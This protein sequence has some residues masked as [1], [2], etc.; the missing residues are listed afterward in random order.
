MNHTE[1]CWIQGRMLAE[2]NIPG[3]DRKG[4]QNAMGIGVY[5]RQLLRD[6]AELLVQIE[7]VDMHMQEGW[8]TLW[9]K[10]VEDNEGTEDMDMDMVRKL[11]EDI[12]QSWEEG[13]ADLK[14]VE[15]ENTH[16]FHMDMEIENCTY[17]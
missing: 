9:H 5:I 3:K 13:M 14:M 12:D 2:L 10:V 7:G 6:E 11:E 4:V 15:Q 16:N 1:Y 8:H 17:P